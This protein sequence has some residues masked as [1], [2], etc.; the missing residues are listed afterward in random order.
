[1]TTQN[2]DEMRASN[3]TRTVNEVIMIWWVSN[4]PI[5]KDSK[6]S[7]KLVVFNLAT[8]RVWI[9]KDWQRKEEVQ[10]HKIASWWRLAEKAWKILEKW[11]KIYIRWYLHN[12]KVQIE[13]EEKQR[14]ITEIILNDFLILNRSKRQNSDFKKDDEFDD[15]DSD[16]WDE[17]WYIETD[18]D[19]NVDTLAK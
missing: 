9:T 15:V 11:T 19:T 3:W 8:R 14:I 6:N 7:Q 18:D 17:S 4:D 2:W 1:M 5:V 16:L 10:Y 13:W 12:R